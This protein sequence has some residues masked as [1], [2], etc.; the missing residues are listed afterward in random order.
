MYELFAPV[1]YWFAFGAYLLRTLA[2][3]VL[4]LWLL[5]LVATPLPKELVAFVREECA[6][7]AWLREHARRKRSDCVSDNARK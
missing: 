7:R 2:F 6:L 4:G 1:A 5:A 3:V